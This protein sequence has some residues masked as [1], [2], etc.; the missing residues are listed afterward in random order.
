[1]L[2]ILELEVV[3]LELSP[4]IRCFGSLPYSSST[5]PCLISEMGLIAG[6]IKVKWMMKFFQNWNIILN[7]AR[8]SSIFI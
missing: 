3:R 1:M 5:L 4:L 2:A 7:E 8:E 6:V